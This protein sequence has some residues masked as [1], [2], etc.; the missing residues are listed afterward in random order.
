MVRWLATLGSFQADG[1]IEFSSPQSGD[2]YMVGLSDINTNVNYNSID[3]AICLQGIQNY[4]YVYESG[5]NKGIFG[6]YDPGDTF[7]VERVGNK[8][9][10]KRNGE[11]FYIS[12]DTS[13]GTLLGDIS[14]RNTGSQIKDV[15]IVDNNKGLQNVDYTYNV[16]G[17]L[18]N[19]NQD[20]QDD[21]DL[22]NFSLKYNNPTDASK[23][24][25]NGNLSLIHI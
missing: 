16:R 5:S 17:W 2:R 19:I 12:T 20:S 21:N 22:F 1:Y 3:H 23:K 10:Y 14:I 15:H 25:F 8:I 4:F 6:N 11:V 24:L 9:H 7:R 13:S 18:K